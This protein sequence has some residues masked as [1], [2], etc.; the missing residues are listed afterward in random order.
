[1]GGVLKSAA[2]NSHPSEGRKTSPSSALPSAF[3][4]HHITVSQ[5]SRDFSSVGNAEPDKEDLV[6]FLVGKTSALSIDLT[7]C[8]MRWES[9]S[10]VVVDSCLPTSTEVISL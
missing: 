7:V 9:F 8:N 3:H 6:A 1:M 4:E 5:V 2:R 10:F